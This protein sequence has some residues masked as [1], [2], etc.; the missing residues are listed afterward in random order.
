MA[1]QIHL[2]NLNFLFCQKYKQPHLPERKQITDM[3]VLG[4]Y[5]NNWKNGILI[6][7]FRNSLIK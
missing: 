1:S 3:Y 7:I 2:E 5:F 4:F 6:T